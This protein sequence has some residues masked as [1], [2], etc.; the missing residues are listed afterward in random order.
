M[1][2]EVKHI[3]T[4]NA[5]GNIML[6]VIRDHYGLDAKRMFREIQSLRHQV[7][8][9]LALKGI[10]YDDLKTALVPDR[11]RRE[12]ALVFDSSVIKSGW[13]GGDIFRAIIPLFDKRSNH[14]VLAGD[15]I[16]DADNQQKLCDAMNEAVKLKRHV[17]FIY[18][19]QFFIV[20]INNLTPA[21]AEHF[22]KGLSSYKPYIGYA[23][24]TCES[25]F[26][27][28]LSTMLCNTFIKHGE[29]ILQ[30][31][32]DDRPNDED[33]NMHGYAFEDS[34]YTCKSI[35]SY[36]Q[37]PL[38]AYKIERPVFKGFE[39]DTEFSLNA[40]SEMPLPLDGF[41]IHVEEAKLNYIKNAKAGSVERAGLEK[42]SAAKL[43]KL[44]S[45]KISASYIYNMAF[46]ANHNVTKFN[47]IIEIPT[48][49]GK[50]RTRLLAALEYKPEEKILRLITLY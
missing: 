38:L 10:R 34:G 15:Y 9:A 4:L 1:Q 44:L 17:D 32:E 6:E 27:L 18:S 47:V 20:Y 33:I 42:I 31:H 39:T 3:H 50:D 26:K 23:D 2:F 36:L 40:V 14:S 28:Y 16:G 29:I 11:K 13:Y 37:G 5:R 22:D 48:K 8:A 21:M 7:E 30:G 45:S 24:T 19:S 12:I 43:K 25:L 49:D 41:M 46:D 35:Q